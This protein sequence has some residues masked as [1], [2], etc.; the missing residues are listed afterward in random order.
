MKIFPLNQQKIILRGENGKTNH[1]SWLSRLS[2][3]KLNLDLSPLT[4]TLTHLFSHR[5]GCG[6]QF[7]AELSC[8]IGGLIIK[9]QNEDRDTLVNIM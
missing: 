9:R 6:Q 2:L 8:R 3:K 4:R 5:D 1:G 7:N